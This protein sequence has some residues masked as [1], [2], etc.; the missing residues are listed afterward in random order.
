MKHTHGC[1]TDTVISAAYY[2]TVSTLTPCREYH[3]CMIMMVMPRTA[4]S[5]ASPF[6]IPTF[7]GADFLA[8]VIVLGVLAMRYVRSRG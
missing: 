4:F 8:P 6:E 2:D 1:S 3:G 5:K 7:G